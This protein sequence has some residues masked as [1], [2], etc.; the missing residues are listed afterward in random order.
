MFTLGGSFSGGQKT[1]KGGEVF[2]GVSWRRNTNILAEV[3]LSDDEGGLFRT[4]NYGF[5]FAWTGNSGEF[6]MACLLSF[7]FVFMFTCCI[8]CLG[9]E[10]PPQC[11]C[12][13]LAV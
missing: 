8:C 9:R 12:G 11:V 13:V 2:N 5:F 6:I 1:D 7:F 4:D 3:I 10:L